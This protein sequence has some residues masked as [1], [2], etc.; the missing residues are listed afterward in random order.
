M[1]MPSDYIVRPAAEF[2]RGEIQSLFNNHRFVHRHLDWRN[3]LDWVAHQPFW[4]L[5][6]NHHLLGALGCQ[7]DPPEAA[8]VRLFACASYLAP[9]Q[10]WDLLFPHVCES[11]AQL[12]PAPLAALALQDWFTTILRRNGFVHHQDIVVLAWH[13][14]G[15]LPTPFESRVHIREM[16][17]ADLPAVAEVDHGAFDPLWQLS[18][19]GLRLA[20][21]QSAYATVAELPG[22]QVIGYQMSTSTL[23]S[24]HLARLAVSQEYQRLGIGSALLDD[25]LAETVHRDIWHVTVN[26]QHDNINSITLYQKTGFELTGESFPIYLHREP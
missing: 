18:A 13:Y 19:T 6:E 24:H 4:V 17:A 25:F 26:T 12:P 21:E 5:E 2:D 10:V 11:L 20:F 16:R 23:Y 15:A 8:W 9:E 14:N 22:R 1:P 3:P 7:P